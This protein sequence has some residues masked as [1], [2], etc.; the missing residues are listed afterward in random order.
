M[1][2]KTFSLQWNLL[3]ENYTDRRKQSLSRQSSDLSENRHISDRILCLQR[4]RCLPA[5][6]ESKERTDLR[7]SRG[8]MRAKFRSTDSARVG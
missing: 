3:R 1:L 6:F 8:D 5:S 7:V 2:K 4:W